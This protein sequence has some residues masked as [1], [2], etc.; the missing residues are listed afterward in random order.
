MP[1][2]R[3]TWKWPLVVQTK[4]GM[5]SYVPAVGG[6]KEA[7]SSKNRESEQQSKFYIKRYQL[8]Q[9]NH[10]DRYEH[11]EFSN[12]RASKERSRPDQRPALHPQLHAAASSSTIELPL[13]STDRSR[14]PISLSTS[15]LKYLQPKFSESQPGNSQ[16]QS[17]QKELVALN[18]S[19]EYLVGHH[20]AAAVRQGN[21]N[22][23]RP[24]ECRPFNREPTQ[25]DDKD[26]ARVIEF[27]E[28]KL[29]EIRLVKS[30]MPVLKRC[31]SNVDY[32]D[33]YKDEAFLPLQHSMSM[34]NVPE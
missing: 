20:S 12:S 10:N 29:E 33:I 11:R 4:I 15:T 13:Q 17:C 27:G 28:L 18:Q 14:Q 26:R 21:P 9:R 23:N 32:Q 2:R 7:G 30:E 22:E 24:R 31:V 19:Y 3:R 25:I 34:Q 1:K 5:H 16:H 6:R 8:I